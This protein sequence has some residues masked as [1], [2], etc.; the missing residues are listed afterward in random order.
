MS[1]LSQLVADAAAAEDAVAHALMRRFPVGAAVR[2]RWRHRVHA[3][4]VTGH[5]GRRLGV[6]RDETGAALT[7]DAADVVES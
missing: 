2:W 5:D 7:V 3:G 1:S 6:R 4:V